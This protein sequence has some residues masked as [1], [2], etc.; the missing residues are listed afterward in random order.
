[1]REVSGPLK[2]EVGIPASCPLLSTLQSDAGQIGPPFSANFLGK[3]GEREATGWSL[4]CA[5][6]PDQQGV[7]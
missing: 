2:Q 1:M 5:F 3:L 6:R 4:K 7:R